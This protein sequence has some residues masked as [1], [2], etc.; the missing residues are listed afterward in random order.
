MNCNGR[1]ETL[2]STWSYDENTGLV[3]IYYPEDY[4]AEY[5]ELLKED[6]PEKEFP[7][8]PV[9]ETFRIT[10]MNDGKLIIDKTTPNIGYEP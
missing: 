2:Q 1:T 5:Y 6:F 4:L 9:K 8:P 3:I 10:S 7:I